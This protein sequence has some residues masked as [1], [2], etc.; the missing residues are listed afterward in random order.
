MALQQR[1]EVPAE[2][3]EGAVLAL[4]VIPNVEDS[5]RPSVMELVEAPLRTTVK[6]AW[7]GTGSLEF[8]PPS[9][10]DPWSALPVRRML[11]A[12]HTLFDFDL[13]PGRVLKRY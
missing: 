3:G 8:G 12:S 10:A 9:E 5:A 1:M 11:S 6:E 4:R 13:L 2:P 7:A